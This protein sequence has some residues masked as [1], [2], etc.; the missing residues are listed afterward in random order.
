M[1]ARMWGNRHPHSLLVGMHNGTATSEDSLVIPYEAIRTRTIASSNRTPWY[2][3]RGVK[4]LY[5][6]QSLHMDI[7]S[8]F[9]HSGQ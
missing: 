6:H 1:L 9:T 4:N 3:H 2:L 5:P 8:S 7:C